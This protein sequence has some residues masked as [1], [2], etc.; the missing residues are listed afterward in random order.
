MYVTP[1]KLVEGELIERERAVNVYESIVNRRRDPA[2]LEQIGDN[3]FRMRVFP[4]PA[5][6][7]KRILLDYTIPLEPERDEYQF[8]LP[9]WS[10]LNPIGDFRLTGMIKGPTRP[11]SVASLSHPR[12][13]VEL[14][15]KTRKDRIA[16]TLE[17]R[18]YRPESFSLKFVQPSGKQP[19]FRSYQAAACRR[20]VPGADPNGSWANRRHLFPGLNSS[21]VCVQVRHR[22]DRRADSGRHFRRNAAQPSAA[23]N[24]P[25]DHWPSASLRPFST[26]MRRRGPPAADGQMACA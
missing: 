1:D 10:D 12:L 19:Q 7:V 3:L 11:D 15:D 4:I 22:P 6:D 16:F 5:Q 23:R 14:P 2:L 24:A 21:A 18:N 17:A 8:Q 20:R 9:L 26:G 13:K 25:H